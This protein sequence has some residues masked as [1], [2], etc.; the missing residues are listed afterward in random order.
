MQNPVP[1]EGGIFKKS[2][3]NIWKESEPPDCDFVIQTMDTAFSTR[4][5]ADYSVIQTWGIFTEKE[6]D[7]GGIEHT[8]G[9]L[10]LLGSVRD[11][12]E[13]PD[14]RAKAQENFEHHEPDRDKVS[15][16]YAASPLLEA[17]RLWLPNKI[18]AQTLFDEAVSF[19]NAAHDDQVDS[20]VMAV[21]YLKE[22]W[23]LQHPYDPSYD[24]E[25]KNTYKKNKATYWNLS[26]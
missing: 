13:Y 14:L 17:G 16:A 20:M 15:R 26:K 19:P 23:H 8:V 18:W 21:L 7:S 2:W 3:F 22:S 24:R 1:D 5:T 4:T 9:H 12:L 25:D 6:V 10:I 11:R